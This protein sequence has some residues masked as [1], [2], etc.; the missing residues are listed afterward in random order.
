MRTLRHHTALGQVGSLLDPATEGHA[1]FFEQLIYLRH[2]KG[3]V[4]WMEQSIGK[5]IGIQDVAEVLQAEICIGKVMQHSR[6]DDLIESFFQCLN[7]QNREVV[8]FEVA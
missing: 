7:I 4:L 6:T 3:A 2:A 1:A 5:S 8:K